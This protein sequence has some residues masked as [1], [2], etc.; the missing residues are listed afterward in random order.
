LVFSHINQ[1]LSYSIS[2]FFLKNIYDNFDYT[3]YNAP[4]NSYVEES[5]KFETEAIAMQKEKIIQELEEL[6]NDNR[7]RT[8]KTND[9]SL[10]NFR[11]GGKCEKGINH[12]LWMSNECK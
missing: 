1:L 3:L 8:I 12:H 11:L 10:Y 5:R 4:S 9:K 6:K 2:I 7:L